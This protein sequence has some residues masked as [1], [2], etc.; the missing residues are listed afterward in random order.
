M[1]AIGPVAVHPAVQRR[2]IGSALMDAAT[3]SPSPAACRRS[4]C[5]AIPTT[6][7]GS[8]SSRRAASGLEPPA[9][10]WPDPAWLARRLPA[11][12]ESMRGTVRYPEAF[13]PLA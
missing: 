6:T 1:L 7:R 5:W 3:A 9:D 4:S 12:D 11:W 2:G 8:A 10:A 13:G